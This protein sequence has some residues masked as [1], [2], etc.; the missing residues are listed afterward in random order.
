VDLELLLYFAIAMVPGMLWLFLLA[1][2]F[3]VDRESRRLILKTFA[4]GMVICVPAGFFN[5]WL[6][7]GVPV[8]DQNSWLYYLLLFMLVVGPN[9]EGLKFLI[10]WSEVYRG[11]RFRTSFD[12]IIFASASAIGFATYENATY[13]QQFGIQVLLVRAW[14]CVIGHLCFSA[15][16]GYYLGLAKARKYNPVPCIAEGLVIAASLHGL[17]DFSVTMHDKAIYVVVP[18]LVGIYGLMSRNM[19]RPLLSILA[20][21]FM[22]Y[23]EDA[24]GRLSYQRRRFPVH[25]TGIKSKKAD[26]ALAAMAQMDDE[27]R[28]HGIEAS[29][30]LDDQRVFDR[31]QELTHDPVEIVRKRA[32]ICHRELRR[33]LSAQ[34]SPCSSR[35]RHRGV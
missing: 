7:T 19:V 8:E 14:A 2:R 6:Q 27:S 10:V 26:A 12:G 31:V 3:R 16:F 20:P 25:L 5:T 28:I 23:R 4:L 32:E 29:N 9:E 11:W 1:L 33:Q 18:I 34:P 13:M 15:V 22:A 21:S 24:A 17:Y 30:G 35:P